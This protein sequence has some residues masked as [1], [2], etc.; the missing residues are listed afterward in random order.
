MANG[1]AVIAY[2][3][4]TN[5]FLNNP[6]IL[7][8]ETD[9][10]IELEKVSQWLYANKLYLNIDKTS[11]VVFHSPQR[12]IVHNMNLRI[13][14]TSIKSDTRVKYLGLILDSNL[15][16]KAYIHEL[17]KTISRGI[18]VLS[19]LRYY[20]KK[21]ILKQ[22]YY[23][24]IYPYMYLT[25]GLLLW[26]NTY[27]SSIKPLII[28]QKRAMR[29]ITFSKPD[30]HSEPLFKELE[31]LK[32]GDLVSLHNALFCISIIRTFFYLPLI[33][34]SNLFHQFTSRKPGLLRIPDQPIILTLSKQTM[35]NSTFALLL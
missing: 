7:N 24:L 22:L 6:Y 35:V 1:S 9:L 8:L 28:L 3:T 18:G 31:I 29:I 23:S 5:L 19:K 26:G 13:S 21:N 10:N 20:V 25:Y 11:F 27:S 32:L 33:T 30:E 15:N 12:R 14:N 2:V 17:S 34:F 4:V 16:W